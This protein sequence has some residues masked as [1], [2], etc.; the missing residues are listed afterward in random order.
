MITESEEGLQRDF[1]ECE[2][3]AEDGND[4]D[5][6]YRL[7]R[8]GFDRSGDA[9]DGRGAA[10]AAAA[11]REQRKRVFDLEETSHEIIERDHDGNN[12]DGSLQALE[13]GT[14]EDDEIELE[15]QQD[16]TGTQ[17]FVG[18][19]RCALLSRKCHGPQQ[20]QAHAKDQSQDQMAD[21][22]EPW[23]FGK[24]CP[25]NEQ[26]KVTSRPTLARRQ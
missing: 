21:E 20:L 12:E 15:A 22:R 23:K 5:G 16:D 24:C 6:Q 4:G 26:A 13:T 14:H 7:I 1:D 17:E 8:L 9:H 11:G 2:Y 18:D 19:E 25:A 3:R 10:D